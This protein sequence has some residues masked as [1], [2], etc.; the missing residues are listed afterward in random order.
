MIVD[1]APVGA[2]AGCGCGAATADPE[3][4]SHSSGDRI[5][6][7]VDLLVIHRGFPRST[8][9][10]TFAGRFTRAHEIR[11]LRM[12][13][14]PFVI[15]GHE[16]TEPGRSRVDVPIGDFPSQ[17]GVH[18][19]VEVVRGEDPGPTIFLSAAIHGDELNGVEVVRQVLGKVSPDT[20]AGT[21]VA[22]PIV[23]VFAFIAESRYLPDR[24]DLNRAFP[25]SARGSMAARLAHLFMK[26]IVEKCDYGIDLHTAAQ[27][28]Y[29]LP[30]VRGDFTDPKVHRIATAFGAP[31]FYHSPGRDGTVRR[32]ANAKGIPVILYEAGEAG[33]FD[34]DSV[35]IG[36]QGTQRVLKELGMITTAPAQRKPSVE[37]TGTKWVRAKRA[38][39][40]RL[41]RFTGDPV[42][43][44]QKIGTIGDALGDESVR[45][46]APCDGI[47]IS[48]STHPLLNQGDAVV[49]L[50]KL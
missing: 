15:A 2:F 24:R 36:V 42:K 33:R 12:S 30:H 13:E 38:G 26:E 46:N 31:V 20:L 40:L 23:N 21:I 3:A 39:V 28:R 17:T 48:H 18:M 27:G 34:L 4:V 43:K 41:T 7:Y 44:R 50:A 29:N 32:A 14:A 10:C 16:F 8:V 5:D 11:Q 6:Q 19:H 22:V 49:H 25:G 9:R 45:V 37:A 47:V 1:L 35:A